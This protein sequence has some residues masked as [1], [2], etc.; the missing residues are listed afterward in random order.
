MYRVVEYSLLALAIYS[1]ILSFFGLIS[2]KPLEL[3]LSFL[4]I[5]FVCYFT[6]LVLGKI[7]KAAINAESSII[8][9]LILFFLL[10]PSF[11][12]RSLLLIAL[13][14]FIAMLSK[15][16]ITYRKKHIFNPAAFG[17][18]ALI[19]FGSGAAWWVATPFLLPAVALIGIFVLRKT[20]K[21]TVFLTFLAVGFIAFLL[22]TF[23][24]GLNTIDQSILFF[25]SFPVIF[26]GSIMLTEPL[27]TP[28]TKKL[29]LVYAAITGII[30][31]YQGSVGSFILTTELA[32][33]FGN[34]FSFLVSPKYKLLLKLISVRNLADNTKEFSFSKPDFFKFKPGQYLEW[35]LPTFKTDSRGNRRYFT[36]ASSPT[37]RDIKISIR[38]S[39]PGS[40]FK[41][42]LQQ[43]KLNEN[44]TAG[45]LS[46]DFTLPENKEKK[47]VFIA[48]GIG[49]TPFRSMIKYLVD[50]N[51]K[52]D[53]V[54]FYLN[55][56][57]GEIAYRDILDE[58]GKLIELKTI[59][60]LTDE[61]ALGNWSGETGRIDE[62]M[63]KK[64]VTDLDG[65]AFYLSGPNAMVENYKKL[66]RKLNVKP[67]SIMTDYFPGY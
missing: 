60:V 49:I 43:L 36:I 25:T 51:E 3:A 4:T 65:V 63:L 34:I 11:E 40:G 47:L 46:G 22:Q 38:F 21:F 20:R 28:P 62:K 57:E 61:K 31:S 15:F 45:Q 24:Q 54:L 41:R 5:T 23:L 53:I 56:T 32:L 42:L 13:A 39:T 64:H 19:F 1:L 9:S 26:F 59:Y 30:F 2:F 27:T 18:V 55:K 14:G 8:T 52:R 7:F 37:E 67:G 33:L 6:N 44:I 48:G 16:V 66:L 12:L 35:T 50:S 17:A 58:A 10:W 29:Q